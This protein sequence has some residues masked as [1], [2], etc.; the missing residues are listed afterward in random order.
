MPKGGQ[1]AV[2][3]EALHLHRLGGGGAT[4]EPWHRPQ[5]IDVPEK[6]LRKITFCRHCGKG[7]LS[8]QK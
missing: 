7:G 3:G 8:V 6:A 2:E 1:E 5:Q 4:R